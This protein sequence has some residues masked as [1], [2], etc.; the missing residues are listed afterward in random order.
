M[1]WLIPPARSS[2]PARSARLCLRSARAGAR[3]AGRS[4]CRTRARS[5]SCCCS[6]PRS[7]STSCGCSNCRCSAERAP[8]GSFGTG[9]LAAFVATPCAGP[10]LGAALGTALAA[11][12]GG[13]GAGVRRA[14]ASGSRLPF[15]AIAFVPALRTQAAQAGAVDEPAAA[16]P[17][18]SDGGERASPRCGC[19]TGRRGDRLCCSDLSRR[20]RSSL[21]CSSP[22]GCSAQAAR[23]PAC[24][25][26]LLRRVVV[27]APLRGDPARRAS[28]RSARRRRRA[29]ERSGGRALRRSRATRCSSISPPTG[30]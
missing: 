25:G 20:P 8:A 7:R 28:A 27:V 17:R 10:F 23:R 30:A 12:A 24:R 3:R 16:L 15:L 26:V 4:S 2:A 11:A 18:H 6:R 22:A 13:L 5:C 14:R 1:R 19:S 29:V 9:A 21:A